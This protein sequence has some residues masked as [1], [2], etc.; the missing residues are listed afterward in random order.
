MATFITALIVMFVAA[1][2]VYHF[3]FIDWR[4][5]EVDIW[6]GFAIVMIMAGIVAIMQAWILF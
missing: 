6:K 5:R 1:V 3:A 2:P 4:G